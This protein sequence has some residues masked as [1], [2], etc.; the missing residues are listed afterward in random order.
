MFISTVWGSPANPSRS[1]AD[2]CLDRC[3][4]QA[5][6][7]PIPEGLRKRLGFRLSSEE[8]EDLHPQRV[9]FL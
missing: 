4:E 1:T 6:R 9:S 8:Y 3:Q 2:C 7:V 5:V